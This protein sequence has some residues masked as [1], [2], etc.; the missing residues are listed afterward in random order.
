MFWLI[1]IDGRQ[2]MLD[3]DL[4]EEILDI[5]A[6]Q[7]QRYCINLSVNPDDEQLVADYEGFERLKFEIL[8]V[9]T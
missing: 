6:T 3:N 5:L 7:E 2:I 4:R 9:L 1:N 8:H